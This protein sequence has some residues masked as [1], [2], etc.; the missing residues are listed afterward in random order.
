M[1]Q[2]QGQ[3]RKRGARAGVK[4]HVELTAPGTGVQV[5]FSLSL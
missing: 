2:Q 3:R 4:G 1:I 5:K